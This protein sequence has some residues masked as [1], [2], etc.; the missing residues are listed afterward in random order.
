M[1]CA[2]AREAARGFECKGV[3]AVAGW[4]VGRRVESIEAM[5]FV[6]DFGTVCHHKSYFSEA[7]DDVFGD[8]G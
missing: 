2:F 8:L 1:K 4:M 5:V 3:L 7:L 6:F